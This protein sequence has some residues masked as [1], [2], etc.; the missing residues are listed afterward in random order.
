[1]KRQYII[2]VSEILDL[3]VLDAVMDEPLVG[4][5]SL[6]KHPFAPLANPHRT[7]VF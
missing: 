5:A 4:V 7:E 3:R 1:M 2:P 6:P